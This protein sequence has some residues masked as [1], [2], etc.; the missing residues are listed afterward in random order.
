MS[1]SEAPA[2]L[3]WKASEGVT[4]IR[5]PTLPNLRSSDSWTDSKQKRK[6]YCYRKYRERGHNNKIKLSVFL[7]NFMAL[8]VVA[9]IKNEF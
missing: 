2:I 4:G 8:T 7:F 9:I 3:F 6:I 1:F 5:P